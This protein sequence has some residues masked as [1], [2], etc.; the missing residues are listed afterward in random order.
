MV[1]AVAWCCPSRT[2][3]LTSRRPDTS[4]VWSVVP[5]EYWRERTPGGNF[6]TLPQVFVEAGFLT[7]G[8]GKIFHPNAGPDGGADVQYSWSPE[9][10]PYD[11]GGS[12]CPS[13]G[14]D[15]SARDRVAEQRDPE[16]QGGP[17]MQPEFNSDVNIASCGARTLRR[18]KANK[19]AGRDSR[20]F[21]LALGFHKQHAGLGMG[22]TR[23]GL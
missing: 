4:R 14:P 8:V 12:K 19:D 20:P 21:F 9:S 22:R 16:L 6:S 17:A 7:L 3:L 1:A 10:L 5:D 13:G 15:P 11:N 18:L 23:G 2:A